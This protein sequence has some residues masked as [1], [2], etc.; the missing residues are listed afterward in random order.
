MIGRSRW[1]HFLFAVSLAAGAVL[2][3]GEANAGAGIGLK[4]A[5]ANQAA[6]SAPRREGTSFVYRDGTRVRAS[7]PVGTKVRC[8]GM[9]RFRIQMEPE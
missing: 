9:A 3:V 6:S 2:F 1:S 5:N 7:D 8:S 4:V